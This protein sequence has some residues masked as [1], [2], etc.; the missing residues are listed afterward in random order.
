MK[1]INKLF[2]AALILCGQMVLLSGCGTK[3]IPLAYDPDGTI[4]SFRI[5]GT[6]HSETAEPFAADLCVVTDNVNVDDSALDMSKASSA[7]LFDLN[8]ADVLYAKNVHEQLQPA[9]LTKLMTALVAMK[10]GNPDDV[11]TASQNVIITE[12]G[13]TLC[14]LQEG[15]QLTLNQALHALLISSANDAAV[16]IA[17]HI[18]GSVEEFTAMM[19]EEAKAIGAT[20]SHFVNPHGLTADNHYVTAYDMYLIFNEAL[21][22]DLINEIIHMTS[23]DLVYT[24]KNGDSKRKTLNNSNQYLSGNQIAPEGVTVIGGKTGTTT[25][26]RNCLIL[27]GRDTSGNPYISVILKAEDRGVLYEEMTGLL[28]KIN[29]K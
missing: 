4:S 23:Y 18:A 17:E 3:E 25:A 21:Q 13:A 8:N 27:L 10:Y 15:D 24:D 1:C 16:A 29:E 9:S 19:N 14:G 22:Y 26:A 11:I 20:N 5:T 7:G 2:F 28:A 6:N 12:P